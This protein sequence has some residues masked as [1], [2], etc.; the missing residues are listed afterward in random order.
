M[1][2]IFKLFVWVSSWCY[3]HVIMGFSVPPMGLDLDMV[4]GG[5]GPYRSQNPTKAVQT[6]YFAPNYC[7][8][9]WVTSNE[10]TQAQVSVLFTGNL[11]GNKDV[12]KIKPRICSC[13][14]IEQF[15]HYMFSISVINQ[16]PMYFLYFRN[17]WQDLNSIH[18]GLLVTYWNWLLASRPWVQGFPGSNPDQSCGFSDC[19]SL[20]KRLSKRIFY[21]VVVYSHPRY[22]LPV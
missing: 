12:K 15:L 22:K 6:N 1:K 16:F 17:S 19:F 10:I 2:K 5:G 9:V 13:L 21:R 8:L 4:G 20:I 3:F 14:N 7:I 18:H 11:T